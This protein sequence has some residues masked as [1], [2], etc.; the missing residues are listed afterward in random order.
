[1]HLLLH[2]QAAA[3]LPPS[4]SD[5]AWLDTGDNAWQMTA[6]TFVALMSVPGLAVLFGGLVPEEMGCQHHV[7]DLCRLCLRPYRVGLVGL[8]DGLR[9]AGVPFGELD[10]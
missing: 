10:G 4:S 5:Q 8:P 6:A 3:S 1:M 9:Y 2:L 7:D